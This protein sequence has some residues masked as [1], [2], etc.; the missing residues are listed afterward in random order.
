MSAPYAGDVPLSNGRQE[1]PAARQDVHNVLDRKKGGQMNAHHSGTTGQL[2]TAKNRR[3]PMSLLT[4][5]LAPDV[6]S[7]PARPHHAPWVGH[8][9][10]TVAVRAGVPKNVPLQGHLLLGWGALAV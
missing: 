2:T 6:T 5:T 1:S 8:A 4:Y 9:V 3:Q 10:S 7:A